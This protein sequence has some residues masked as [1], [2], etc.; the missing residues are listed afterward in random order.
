[1]RQAGSVR[2]DR[3]LTERDTIEGG[4]P[5]ADTVHFGRSFEFTIARLT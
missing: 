2:T 4:E 3:V 1:M 5:D